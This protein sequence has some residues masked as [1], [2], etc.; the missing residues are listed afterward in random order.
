MKGW[1]S[2]FVIISTLGTQMYLSIVF[3]WYMVHRKVPGKLPLHPTLKHENWPTIYI[4][5]MSY[6]TILLMFTCQVCGEDTHSLTLVS[7]SPQSPPPPCVYTHV[8]YSNVLQSPYIVCFSQSKIDSLLRIRLSQLVC[9]P[10]VQLYIH[11]LVGVHIHVHRLPH[12]HQH[13]IIHYIHGGHQ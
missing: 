12:I 11:T 10:T 2:K 1:P 13:C 8:M 5:T 3:I 7:L 4:H 9:I 6:S